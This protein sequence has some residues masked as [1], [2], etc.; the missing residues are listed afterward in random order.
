MHA[1]NVLRISTFLTIAMVCPV[2]LFKSHDFLASGVAIE[3]KL[4]GDHVDL[5]EGY[6]RYA[7]LLQGGPSM[8]DFSSVKGTGN[9]TR[10]KHMKQA[11]AFFICTS[12][13]TACAGTSS[14]TDESTGSD[15]PYGDTEII[16]GGFD[17]AD[18]VEASDLVLIDEFVADQGSEFDSGNPL[19]NESM[20][21]Q[22]CNTTV[23]CGPGYECAAMFMS[24][25]C[26]RICDPGDCKSGYT[27]TEIDT[28]HLCAPNEGR[29]LN[30]SEDADCEGDPAFT[31]KCLGASTCELVDACFNRCGWPEPFCVV[32]LGQGDCVQCL[33]D[34]DCG[35]VG[36]GCFCSGQPDYTCRNSAGSE[37]LTAEGSCATVCEGVDDCPAMMFEG[38][39][40]CAAVGDSGLSVCIDQ[41]AGC[42]W[43]S[44]CCGPG[45]ACQ[46]VA[47]TII[48]LMGME[49]PEPLQ[50]FCGCTETADCIN[51]RE[52]LDL[53]VLCAVGALMGTFDVEAVCPG[54]E[55]SAEMPP[56]VCAELDEIFDGLF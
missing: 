16:D 31:G 42:D 52:C 39:A 15:A 7:G 12:L 36:A 27:C 37:C 29:C 55:L 38:T 51:G 10:N 54:G 32:E 48:G 4:P 46:D 49:P 41:D 35:L 45:Q 1:E 23:D 18:S 11:G 47:G 24:K 14:V 26:L 33:T 50:G 8:T 20:I 17:V 6:R 19:V 43:T 2:L 40:G 34:A 21:C 56:M 25:C 22:S 5:F 44:Y 28:S 3:N 53:E 30:C 13:L 9:N